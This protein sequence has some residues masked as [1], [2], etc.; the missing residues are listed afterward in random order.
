VTNVVCKIR[1]PVAVARLTAG[2]AQRAVH[3]AAGGLRVSLGLLSADATV[4]AIVL[5]GADPAFR[6]VN[7]SHVS[8]W[9]GM[10]RV[11]VS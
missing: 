4:R 6:A 10:G 5:T 2:A 11:G 8:T 9:E 7:L 1:G 3:C